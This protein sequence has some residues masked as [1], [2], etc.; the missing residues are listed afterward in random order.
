MKRS[1]LKTVKTQVLRIKEGDVLLFTVGDLEK[2]LIPTDRDLRN[3]RKLLQKEI[4]LGK[5]DFTV[6]VFPPYIKAAIVRKVVKNSEFQRLERIVS[7]LMRS[8]VRSGLL[9]KKKRS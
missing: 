9:N 1:L 2:N 5:K 7:K 3:F 4:K 8:L 6:A